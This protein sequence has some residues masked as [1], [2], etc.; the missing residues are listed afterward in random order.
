[1]ELKLQ[2]E[3]AKYIT[4]TLENAEAL[5]ANP[6]LLEV[7]ISSDLQLKAP[8]L[9]N[10]VVGEAELYYGDELIVTCNLVTT[11]DILAAG[12]QAAHKQQPKSGNKR[13][14]T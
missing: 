7:K 11:R 1:M 8:V 6:D 2:P 12:D 14:R 3:G 10:V 5:K 9:K 4:T 13:R